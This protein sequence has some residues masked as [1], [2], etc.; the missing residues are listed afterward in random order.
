MSPE[1]KALSRKYLDEV[2]ESGILSGMRVSRPRGGKFLNL[3]ETEVRAMFGVPHAV[4]YSSATTA[5][6]GALRA[7]GIGP[8]DR[9]LVSGLTMTASAAAVAHLGATP[10]FVDVSKSTGLVTM[11]TIREALSRSA[12][13]SPI[14][15]SAL[16]L[17]HL[18]GQVA[19]T[20][21]IRNE[22]PWLEIVED[23]AQAPACV[24]SESEF[25][26]TTGAIGVLSLN[27]HKVIQCGEGGVAMTR[28]DKLAERLRLARNHGENHSEDVLG[29][30]YRMTELEA[31]V[32][33]AEI[34][35]LFSRQFT[36][37]VSSELLR[38]RL[39]SIESVRPQELVNPPYVFYV[40]DLGP[41]EPAPAGWRRGYA[42]PLCC[43]PY[44]KRRFSDGCL[45]GAHEFVASILTTD[46]PESPEE[47]TLK[48]EAL[49]HFY[50]GVARV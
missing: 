44:F 22:F 5:L 12:D 6:E 3:L 40:Q 4:S 20:Y 24:D 31:A 42:T 41:P 47:A 50:R 43:I 39:L 35:E 10:V 37:K 26:G 19:D 46:P 1:T 29:S 25:A 2:I 8:S 13:E 36:R 32:A 18:F 28:S 27:Q 21:P 38:A 34:S 7:L 15:P 30:N 11:E 16:V 14:R 17:V 23:T 33:Y 49:I 48:A 9:V 45:L